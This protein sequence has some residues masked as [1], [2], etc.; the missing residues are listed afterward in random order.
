[1]LNVYKIPAKE[2]AV[3]DRRDGNEISVAHTWFLKYLECVPL[4]LRNDKKR[5]NTLIVNFKISS[6]LSAEYILVTGAP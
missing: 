4:K 3:V 5:K 1:M 2:H 6:V